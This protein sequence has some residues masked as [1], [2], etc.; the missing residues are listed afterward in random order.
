[1]RVQISWK[2]RINFEMTCWCRANCEKMPGILNRFGLYY[3]QFED[4]ED[5]TAFKLRFNL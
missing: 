5:A 1:M 2:D 4:A 3:L